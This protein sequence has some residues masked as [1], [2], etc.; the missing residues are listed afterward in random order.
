MQNKISYTAL[1]INSGLI[2]YHTGPSLDEGPLPS[3]FYFALSGPGSLCLDPFNQP[4]QFLQGKRIRVFSLTLPGHEEGLPPTEA[5]GLWAKD[6]ANG[7]DC[8]GNFVSQAKS[9]LKFAIH[10]GLIDPDRVAA[11][12]LSRGGFLAAHFAASSEKI[13]YLL[14]FAPLTRLSKIKEFD[15][16]Q[17]H[18][19][20]R[21]LDLENLAF[22]LSN[23]HIRLYIGNR[24]TRVG[25]T[26]CFE[27]AM[28]LVA[29]AHEKK[30]RSPQIELIISPSIGQMG[31]GTSPEIF[32][33]GAEWIRE[34]LLND[35]ASPRTLPK[36]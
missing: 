28:S 32:A 34:K 11:A 36:N 22:D 19:H 13:R 15:E 5:M 6:L 24:D 17:D 3:L 23:R 10:E 35:R 27:F 1:E 8:V 14:G 33:Q 12:G 20:V 16:L 30:I 9:A 2:L 4:V 29:R 7:I 25:T 21:A 26:D 18:P 31:H